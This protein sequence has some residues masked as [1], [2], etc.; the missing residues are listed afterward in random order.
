MKLFIKNDAVKIFSFRLTLLIIIAIFSVFI[1]TFGGGTIKNITFY[2][3]ALG[4]VR[5]VQIYL[6]E[7]YNQHDTTVRYPVV[8][9][10]HGAGGNSYAHSELFRILDNLIGKDTI[11]PVIL[12]KPDGS[13]QPWGSSWYTNSELYGN[14]EDCIVN[15]LIAFIDSAYYTIDSREKRAIMGGSMGGCGAMMLALKHPDKYCGVASHSGELDFIHWL[16]LIPFI[17][18]ENG[19]APVKAFNPNAGPMTYGFFSTSGAFSPNLD[20]LPYKV[21]LLIDSIGTIIDSVWKRWLLYDPAILAR[22]L[23]QSSDLAIYFDCGKQDFPWYNFNKS[24]PD[25]LD[26]FGLTYQFKSY[27]GGHSDQWPNR[28]PIALKF[29]DSVMNKRTTFVDNSQNKNIPQKF[30]LYQNYPNP[31]NPNTKI[32]F[33]IPSMGTSLMKFVQIKV[34][35]ILGREVA[36]L[37][38]E[39]KKAGNYEVDFNANKL[40]SGTYFYQLKAGN[41]ISTKKM[42]L[43]K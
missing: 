13:A 39:E 19:G 23:T 34:Y 4:K 5:N 33:S 30:I 11:L 27:N 7:G 10:L 2:S 32:K 14:Y 36:T 3:N 42:L 1:E 43:A 9:F 26:K 25:S 22:N 16:D 38:N 29:L 15:D 31:F 18:A 6:P 24:F 12:V 35:D 17:I 20:N 40:S 8:Y 21:D 37:V 28:F 41:I